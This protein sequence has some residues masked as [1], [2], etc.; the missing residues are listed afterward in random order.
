VTW[1]RGSTQ[2]M[3]V[4]ELA[5]L[6]VPRAIRLALTI[7]FIVLN[8][9]YCIT[10]ETLPVPA[11][12][13]SGVQFQA[14]RD[15]LYSIVILEGATNNW[16]ADAPTSLGWQ[17]WLFIYKN[18]PIE[19]G[20]NGSYGPSATNPDFSVG[21]PAFYQT[22]DA[23]ESAGQG[24]SVEVSLNKGDYII[25]VIQDCL[26]YYYDNR[27]ALTVRISSPG[28][29]DI[30]VW[31]SSG[32]PVLVSGPW[33]HTGIFDGVNEKVIE[34]RSV[35]APGTSGVAEHPYSDWQYPNAVA[36]SILRVEGASLAQK[37]AAVAF[38]REQI[39]KSYDYALWQKSTLGGA[40]YCSELVWAAYKKQGIALEESPDSGVVS[41]SEIYNSGNTTVVDSHLEQDPNDIHTAFWKLIIS[42]VFAMSPVE[43]ELEAPDGTTISRDHPQRSWGQ[44]MADDFDGDGDV[45]EAIGIVIPQEGTYLL[46]LEPK[47]GVSPSDTYTLDVIQNGTTNRLAENVRVDQIPATPYE[48]STTELEPVTNLN[49]GETFNSIQTAIDD[50]DT[51]DGHTIEVN[52]SQYDCS[53]EPGHQ[54]FE[55]GGEAF[56][57][58]WKQVTV[59]STGGSENTLLDGTGHNVIIDITADNVAL[60][61]FTII[62]AQHDIG[63]FGWS[64]G[65]N[66]AERTAVTID[67]NVVTGNDTCGIW[68]WHSTYCEITNNTV[69]ETNPL[70]NHSQG[71]G[72]SINEGTNHTTIEGN[73]IENNGGYGIAI[74]DSSYNT[75]Q[76]NTIANNTQ[77]GIEVRGGDLEFP[78]EENEITNNTVTGTT[79]PVGEYW[80]AGIHLSE[81]DS[82]YILNNVVTNNADYGIEIWRSNNCEIEE[83]TVS[84]TTLPPGD[85]WG[86]HGIEVCQ[87]NN[88][89]VINNTTQSNENI[90]I[91]LN[92]SAYN[93]VENNAVLS[94]GDWGINLHSFWEDTE[95]KTAQENDII[96]NT[97]T[98]NTVGGIVLGSSK[99]NTIDGN[100]FSGSYRG[101]VLGNTVDAPCSGNL[102]QN[103]TVHSNS[104]YGIS[105]SSNVNQ[106]EIVNNE[107]YN[108]Y[109]SG[110]GWVQGIGI[111][112]WAAGC[113]VLNEGNVFSGNYVHD[114]AFGIMITEAMNCEVVNNTVENNDTADFGI[115]TVLLCSDTEWWEL[116]A[117]IVG[118][119]GIHVNGPDNTV[120]GNTVTG[121]GYG[122]MVHGGD[123][124]YASTGNDVSNNNVSNNTTG[125]VSMFLS[126]YEW[127]ESTASTTPTEQIPPNASRAAPAALSRA[128]PE[129]GDRLT[130]ADG[131]WENTV[132]VPLFDVGAFGLFLLNCST[133][134]TSDNTFAG[135]GDFGVGLRGFSAP[136]YGWEGWSNDNSVS[137]TDIQQHEEGV[138]IG[139][140]AQDNLV[141]HTTIQNNISPGT[142]VEV[143]EAQG[144][145][146]YCNQIVGNGPHGVE[147]TDDAA[148]E[149]YHNWWGSTNGPGAD[150]ANDVVGNVLYDPWLTSAD[151]STSAVFRVES[152]TGNVLADGPFYGDSFLTGCAD[153]AEWVPV[154]EPVEP[155]DVLELDP[156]SPGQYRKAR[157]PCSDLVAGVVSSAPGVILGS[158]SPTLDI[159]LW[160]LDSALL[161]LLGIVPVKVTDEGGPIQ[162]GDLLVT[163]STPGYAMRWNPGTG[164][165]CSLVG[166]A[167]EPLT[168]EHGIILVLLTAH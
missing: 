49:T 59:Q 82:S 123:G 42:A 128:I 22:Y 15:G 166:K 90:G 108:T 29:G 31:S 150:G 80:G 79:L 33:T 1:D 63:S 87:S 116:T 134:E 36:V 114:N 58:I 2:R 106:N 125:S 135:N 127:I 158:F 13:A 132:F 30:L 129:E 95:L 61:G 18:R 109:T 140:Q 3:E 148:L 100:T 110:D 16:A 156:T 104:W 65:I 84:G 73:T 117:H 9:S 101:I 113:G 107:I 147:N 105:L 60:S 17:S 81:V 157:G 118:G 141:H 155:G 4:F 161:A 111:A 149:A 83:N 99:N 24:A 94:N 120:T 74:Y 115:Y 51:Q 52:S 10:A 124:A 152:A 167:L 25:L 44:Y 146:L 40:W 64:E 168:E 86:G 112:S 67:A 142:G 136:E 98:G 68:L 88:N 56:I 130:K 102:I 121:S 48:I 27:G 50:P 138:W 160:T 43:L 54:P 103:N 66:V 97:V 76:E 37:E 55:D 71:N 126:K 69:S 93:I 11:T 139:P 137:H 38:A 21:D 57:K 12:S 70:P 144:N 78:A 153:V 39:G 26:N 41:P 75:V 85:D 131:H 89:L 77:H 154:S 20:P 23:A 91:V 143:E 151:C 45:D 96:D 32:S 7:F 34:A 19:W 164:S 8:A 162:P 46:L 62:G 165:A 119:G 122:I 47:A 92:G 53:E 14:S 72:I 145:V 5:S 28:H 159:R 35:F 6:G 163:S 133:T